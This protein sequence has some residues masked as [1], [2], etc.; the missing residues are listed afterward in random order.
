MVYLKVYS[1]AT[2]CINKKGFFLQAA[3]AHQ[4]LWGALT[5]PK[6]LVFFF[7]I[8]TLKMRLGYYARGRFNLF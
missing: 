6:L 3:R 1:V 4:M 8:A 5:P 2:G 7:E